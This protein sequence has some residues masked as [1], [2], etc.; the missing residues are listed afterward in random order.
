MLAQLTRDVMLH[1]PEDVSGYI[2]TWRPLQVTVDTD[3]ENESVCSVGSREEQPPPPPLH[4]PK[5][6]PRLSVRT[7]PHRASSSQFSPRSKKGSPRK[8]PRTGKLSPRHSPSK[9]KEEK[10]EEMNIFHQGTLEPKSDLRKLCVALSE[11]AKTSSLEVQTLLEDDTAVEEAG[12]SA[13][14]LR[15]VLMEGNALSLDAFGEGVVSGR[16]AARHGG[17]VVDNTAEDVSQH[18]E[19]WLLG[20]CKANSASAMAASLSVLLLVSQGLVR[21][22][23]EQQ[24]HIQF[25]SRLASHEGGSGAGSKQITV[26]ARLDADDAHNTPILGMCNPLLDMTLSIDQG[27]LD[28]WGIEADS[29]ALASDQHADLFTIM[30]CNPEVFQIEDGL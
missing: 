24:E 16:W 10:G 14:S 25:L 11:I 5:K 27:F 15:K 20:R 13:P 29:A 30:V 2:N 19:R 28:S 26:S 18:L 6:K 23:D 12:V 3:H 7:S 21:L 8:L 9:K 1:R 22:A 4:S 17:G